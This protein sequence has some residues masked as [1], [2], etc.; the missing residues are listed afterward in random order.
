MSWAGAEQKLLCRFLLCNTCVTEV[1]FTNY[2]RGLV[3]ARAF[4]AECWL[5]GDSQ[6]NPTNYVSLKP[7]IRGV[8]AQGPVLRRSEARC[9]QS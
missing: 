9:T 6:C 1:R 8:R 7:P 4:L 3:S 2:I 5:W